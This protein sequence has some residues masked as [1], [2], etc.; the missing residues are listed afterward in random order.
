MPPLSRL[1]AY[2]TRE[3]LREYLTAQGLCPLSTSIEDLEPF[4]SAIVEPPITNESLSELDLVRIVYNA[5]LRH[6]LNFGH[7]IAF[8]PN[9][10]GSRGLQ[11]EQEGKQYWKAIMIELQLYLRSWFGDC[12][13]SPLLRPSK[14]YPWVWRPPLL[15]TVPQR[16]PR[17]LAAIR[18][19]V[20]T[21]VPGIYWNAVDDRFDIALR[22][23]ELENGVYDLLGL[24][25]WLSQ[26]LLKSCSPLRDALVIEMVSTTRKGIVEKD[27]AVLV[28]GLK[29]LFDILETMK[30]DVANHQIRYLRLYFLDDGIEF[31][32][33]YLLYCVAHG[34]S[35]SR[36]RC[37]FEASYQHPERE[38]PFL[39]F[40]ESV[41]ALVTEEKG[42]FPTTFCH[43]FDRLR[44]L[45]RDYRRCVFTAA[46]STT[47]ENALRR[48]KWEGDA[49]ADAR[50]QLLQRIYAIAENPEADTEEPIHWRSIAL[51]ISRG[52]LQLRSLPALPQ[53][54]FEKATESN[55]G[56]AL[57]PASTV[58][59][60]IRG[61]VRDEIGKMVHAEAEKIYDKSPRQMLECLYAGPRSSGGVEE[62]ELAGVSKRVAHLLVLHWKVWAPILYQQR[63]ESWTGEQESYR[64]SVDEGGVT[65]T[66]TR[67]KLQP[68]SSSSSPSSSPPS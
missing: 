15:H 45:Q 25:S 28:D 46:C 23:Q 6:D 2:L 62:M 19:I 44:A 50:N 37:W 5:R 56:N 63:G 16:L 4:W 52:A 32:Q 34:W 18:D 35:V 24:I 65:E 13:R 36:A 68:R 42:E 66:E 11:K 39:M 67:Q 30:L 61:R 14:S 20:K 38:D 27:T 8:K 17:M 58:H 57:G 33:S 48:A 12:P 22:I 29:K 26:L 53:E 41:I 21:L 10:S 64:W 60:G 3:N 59:E 31:E 55:L 7:E 40:K 49:P 51:E 43:D 47:F 9:T 1:D 54:A